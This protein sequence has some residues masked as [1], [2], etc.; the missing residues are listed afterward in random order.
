MENRLKVNVSRTV[1]RT[2][3]Y[4]PVTGR[5]KDFQY[6]FLCRDASGALFIVELQKYYE[7]AWFKRCV[8]YASRAYSNQSRSGED[9]DVPP[10]YLIGLMGVPIMH[11]DREYWKDM[12]ISEYAF[13]D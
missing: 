13:R 2:T 11:P 10:V 7:T 4:G 6:D 5:N 8:S 1:K 3:Q 12:Y 9:Y